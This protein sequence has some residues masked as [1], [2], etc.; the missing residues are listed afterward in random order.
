MKIK[1]LSN[2]FLLN[3]ILIFL[4][5]L[6]LGSL[7]YYM[8]LNYNRS[9]DEFYG[10]DTGL[11]LKD[12]TSDGLNYAFS[13]QAF[14]SGD[15]VLTLTPKREVVETTTDLYTIGYTFSERELQELLYGEDYYNYI[16]F[17]NE[18]YSK[19]FVLYT[20]YIDYGY[21][22]ITSILGLTILLF[23]L[24]AFG[25]ANYTSNQILRPILQLVNGV[26]Q[27]GHGDYKTQIEFDASNELN[28]LKTEI[29]LMTKKIQLETQKRKLTEEKRKQLIRDISHDVR[30][31]LTNILGYSNQLIQRKDFTNDWQQQSIE[32]I[33]QYGKAASHLIN[34][35][36]DLSRLEISEDTFECKQT[37]MTE[38]LRLKLIE[39]INEFDQKNITYNF[40][41]PDTPIFLAI[42]DLYLQRLI[43]NL[44]INAM[45]Y[46]EEDLSIYVEFREEETQYKL[47]VADNGIGIPK[48]VH[49]K[50]FDPLVRVESSR[51]RSLGG[52]GLGL[53]IVKQVADK[54][55]WTITLLAKEEGFFTTGC[56]FELLIPR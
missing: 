55:G 45:T 14:Q 33:H 29:N 28:I 51:N 36:F 37:N 49:P 48:E 56:T 18:D 50:I 23:I 12:Y 17:Y 2:Q 43:D 41:I 10:I 9:L 34:E 39:Y 21:G 15:Y 24:L 40:Q 16:V 32:I 35:L 26:Q 4:L 25:F 30:T 38:W 19:L 31:P 11:F 3:Y 7:A 54:H 52:T 46:N 6:V 8:Y 20:V 47:I 13:N 53:S 5:I 1:K 44:L 27:I 22:H 42:N